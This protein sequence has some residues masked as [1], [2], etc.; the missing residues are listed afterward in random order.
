[1]VVI[2]PLEELL[3]R[4]LGR[5]RSAEPDLLD[6]L[7]FPEQSLL[8]LTSGEVFH[9]G[10]GSLEPMRA[11]FAYFPDDVWLHR[12][13][14]QWQ[15]IAEEESLVGRC[16]EAGDEL[17][18]RIVAARVSRDM[19]RLAFLM[20]RR[21]A[22]YSKWLGTAFA[23][24]ACAP[25]LAPLLERAL[26]ADAYAPREQA[27]AQAG[28][29]LAKI[30]NALEITEPLDPTPR[31]FFSRPYQVL[32]TNRFDHAIREKIQDPRL[33]ALPSQ[34]PAVDQLAD[35]AGATRSP[36]LTGRMR[37]IYGDQ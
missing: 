14:C 7:S 9:D 16:A 2:C 11:R 5:R 24:L 28:T 33:R 30:H 13:S 20:E 6:W 3:A 4:T 17:G 10:L 36:I 32:F 25:R 12:L 21:Y 15:R 31:N 22:P 8:E 34:L 23:R 19:M 26:A 1:M 27:L 18:S 35:L 29:E 37:K